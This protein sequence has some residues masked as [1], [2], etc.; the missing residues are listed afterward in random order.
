MQ[1][2]L[3]KVKRKTARHFINIPG[4]RTNRKIVVIE[5][6]DWGSIRMPSREVYER[7]L[8][9][10]IK[11]NHCPY[12]RY[13]SLASE[14]DL[15]AL[16]ELLK[17]F[18]D[19]K[20]NHPV[21]T[22]NTVLANPDFE[23]IRESGFEEYFY[24]NF[25]ETL[26]KHPNHSKSFNLWKQGIESKVFF[27]QF[28]GREHLNIK[29]WL[30][31]LRNNHG[32]FRKAFDHGFWGLGTD[33]VGKLNINIQ[34]AFDTEDRADI[35]NQK[36]IIKDGLRLFEQIF[37][38]Q[39]RSFIANNFIW[40]SALNQTLFE[41]G[42]HF[43]Q[44]MKYQKLPKYQNKR[45]G[46]VRHYLGEKNNSGQIHL[47]RNCVFEPSQYPKNYDSAG[48]CLKEIRIAFLW[49][50]PAIIS[51]HRLN[52]IG[53]LV[54]SNREQNLEKLSHLIKQIQKQ[55]PDVEFMNSVELG[56]LIIRKK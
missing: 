20:G 19:K 50:K 2:I 27:P 38:F 43:L 24:E 41:N 54:R 37:G 9:Q 4:W 15:E 56:D 49:K 32:L 52:F 16:F 31:H 47:I 44:G 3:K 25:T 29:T 39:S 30:M 33:I 18:K 34:A 12:N 11:V 17:R 8:K 46:M 35:S 6:D 42:I 22:A 26:K 7:F 23:K 10:G 13:D 55:W 28:H 36:E 14:E 40:D 51:A 45:R 48:R 21:I 53:S 1:V 5:S